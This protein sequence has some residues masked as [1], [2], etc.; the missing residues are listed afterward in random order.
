MKRLSKH[1]R[2]VASVTRAIKLGKLKR[3]SICS[4]CG[5][6]E[7]IQAHHADYRKHLDV[8]WLC[9]GCH[10]ERHHKSRPSGEARTELITARVPHASK[11]WL[12]KIAREQGISMSAL[13]E[14]IL[15]MR[16]RHDPIV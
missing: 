3:P 11:V 1:R 6:S 12:K 8:E 9:R 10:Y 13:L 7:K 5:G 16:L 14:A 15:I 2:A 4:Q